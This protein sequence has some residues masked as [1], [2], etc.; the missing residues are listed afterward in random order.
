MNLTTGWNTGVLKCWNQTSPKINIQHMAWA[1]RLVMLD[2]ANVYN[3]IISGETNLT[4]NNEQTMAAAVLDACKTFVRE[5]AI[6][7]LCNATNLSGDVIKKMKDTRIIPLKYLHF[8][9]SKQKVFSKY[10]LGYTK[11]INSTLERLCTD[12]SLELVSK[13]MAFNV[14]KTKGACYKLLDQRGC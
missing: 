14:F 3:M 6:V 2:I 5:K 13:G 11:A 12:G 10:R 1:M 9:L 7:S 8:V 4:M